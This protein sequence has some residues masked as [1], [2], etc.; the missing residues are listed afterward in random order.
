MTRLTS[1]KVLRYNEYSL[2]LQIVYVSNSFRL[3]GTKSITLGTVEYV[4][5]GKVIR[6]KIV[7]EGIYFSEQKKE[8]NLKVWKRVDA[9]K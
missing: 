7:K 2:Q 4:Q 5:P 8:V 6:L 9:S 1:I 3:L